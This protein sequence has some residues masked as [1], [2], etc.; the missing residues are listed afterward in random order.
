MKKKTALLLALVMVFSL[1]SCGISMGSEHAKSDSP[2][3]SA[4]SWGSELHWEEYDALI[5]EI[6]TT[7]DPVKRVEL[8]HQAE[9]RLMDTWAIVPIY[10]YNDPYLEKDYVAGLYADAFS[11]KYF[12][13]VELASGKDTMNVNLA[14]EPGHLD[15][16]LVS[17]TGEQVANS[18]EGLM[19]YN[20]KG[21]LIPAQAEGYECSEDGLT[22]TF[23]MREGLK[24]SNGDALT[25]KDFEYSWRRA[26]EAGNGAD[27]AYLFEVFADSQYDS[28][29]NFTGLGKSSVEASADGRTL[30]AHLNAPCP[31]FLNLC[32]FYTFFP[33]HQGTVEASAT[34]ALPTGTWA[35][36]AG[37]AYVCNGPF[38]LKKWNHDSDM[39]YV[40][41]ENYWDADSVKLKTLNYMLSADDS[42]TY[43]AYTDGSL[44]FIDSI[45]NDELGRLFAA[46]DPELHVADVLGTFYVLFNYNA[47]LYRELGLDEEQAKVFRHA[48][49]LLVDRQYIVDNIG[50]AG[51][52][53]A[54][55]VV[56]PS[57]ADGN[58]G[59]FK[60][61]DYY[62]VDDY[63]ANVEEAKRLLESIGLWD[64]SAL[65]RTVALTYKVNESE[66]FVQIAQALQQDWGQLGIEVTI[67]TEDW[68]V[69]LDER[70]SG[71]YEVA[72]AGWWMDYNDP[73]NMLEMWTTNSGNNDCQFGRAAG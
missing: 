36:D 30:T 63:Q 21:E 13:R 51:Q 5:Q 26:A 12:S 4:G 55:T 16:A 58:G 17:S 40:K 66:S 46:G 35:N 60:D 45:S 64:G 69:L 62:R 65:T 1:A 53:S 38:K 27:Y 7:T 22:Y 42:V 33:V 15:P 28:K 10:Y 31:Y 67:Q 43:A 68:N 49:C 19:R 41:N 8:M 61:R 25:A 23:T 48:L 47:P 14:G 24:W 34:K 59:V 44:D 20:E 18:F 54:T 50:K 9:D 29:G 6:R 72:R 73:I 57:C 2:A 37:D 11:T 52:Q 3:P 71:Q 56:C 70:E 39:T 32:S